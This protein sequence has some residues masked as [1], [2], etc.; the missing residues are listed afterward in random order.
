MVARERRVPW[1]YGRRPYDGGTRWA[2]LLATRWRPELRR[3]TPAASPPLRRATPASLAVCDVFC[4]SDACE[5]ARTCE[6]VCV[7]DGG[8][9]T[10]EEPDANF[11]SRAACAD[12]HDMS[13]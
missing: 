8:P 11:L 6:Y 3:I 12:V 10:F 1:S 9:S 4:E 5:C 7:R 13:M 2:S